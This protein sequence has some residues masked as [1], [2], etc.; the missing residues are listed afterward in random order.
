MIVTFFE[1]TEIQIIAEDTRDKLYLKHVLKIDTKK[2]FA[3]VKKHA[4]RY[5]DDLMISLEPF[6]EKMKRPRNVEDSQNKI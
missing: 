1:E 3:R 6:D 5:E 4:G 2:M